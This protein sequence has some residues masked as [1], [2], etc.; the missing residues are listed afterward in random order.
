MSTTGRKSIHAQERVNATYETQQKY[1]PL[2]KLHCVILDVL[3]SH[4]PYCSEFPDIF[5]EYGIEFL[6]FCFDNAKMYRLRYNG[7][8]EELRVIYGCDSNLKGKDIVVF[9]PSFS[10][11]DVYLAKF[12]FEKI[13]IDKVQ[14]EETVLYQSMSMIGGFSNGFEGLDKSNKRN[15]FEG[16]GVS[17]RKSSDSGDY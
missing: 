4:N 17:S 9:S 11:I 14:D 12:T 2:K 3:G 10:D 15:R 13:A 6:I 16:Y 8:Y 5:V 1:I 7:S